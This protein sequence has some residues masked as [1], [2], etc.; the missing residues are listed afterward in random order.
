MDL[1]TMLGVRP[2]STRAAESEGDR[3]GCSPV[4]HTVAP[5]VADDVDGTAIVAIG[6]AVHGVA[7]AEREHDPRKERDAGPNVQG[8]VVRPRWI[9]APPAAILVPL[10]ESVPDNCHEEW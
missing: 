2:L 7:R 5:T 3:A 8:A 6:T 4:G 1:G 9:Q 10:D